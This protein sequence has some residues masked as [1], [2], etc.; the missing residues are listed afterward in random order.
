VKAVVWVRLEGGERVEIGDKLRRS[1][2]VFARGVLGLTL[3]SYQAELLNCGSKRVVACWA[4]QT[5]KTTA[6]AVRVIHFAF[7]NADTTTLIVSRGLRQ[8]MIMFGVIERFIVGHPVLR[9]SVVRSTRTLIQLSNGSQI[10][11][12]LVVLMG[13]GFVVSRRIL[14]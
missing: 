4:R 6:I 3:F 14:L 2:V 11:G 9:R 1:P 12:C 10:I 5:G 7:T 8:S 13:L